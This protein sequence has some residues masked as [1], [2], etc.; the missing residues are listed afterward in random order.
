MSALPGPLSA[1]EREPLLHELA[2]LLY[3]AAEQGP[4]PLHQT[5]LPQTLHQDVLVPS[6][7]LVLGDRG[8]GKSAL[9]GLLVDPPSTAELRAL[10][11]QPAL[12]E[13][14]YVEGFTEFGM[15]HPPVTVLED[16]ALRRSGPAAVRAVWMAHLLR[17][18]AAAGVVARDDQNRWLMDDSGSPFGWMALAPERVVQLQ[19]QLDEAER[20]LQQRGR[21]VVV[22]YDQLDR[23]GAHH[24]EVQRRAIGTLLSLWL[25]LSQRYRALRGKIFLRDDV[26]ERAEVDFPD[27]SKLRRSQS[28]TLRWSESDL[29]RVALRHMVVLCPKLSEKLR[30]NP[31]LDGLLRAV[32]GFGE[33]P[34]AMPE[35]MQREFLRAL[36]GVVVG[37]GLL[38][39]YASRWLLSAILDGRRQ[40]A[41]RAMLSAIGGAAQAALTGGAGAAERLLSL[42]ELREGVRNAGLDRLRELREAHPVVRRVDQLK[43]REVPINARALERWL[44]T[45]VPGE[46]AELAVQGGEE[47]RQ[48]LLRLGV[49][50]PPD[51][52]GRYDLPDLFL[53]ALGATRVAVE[54]REQARAAPREDA[55]A[56]RVR[57][58]EAA[59]QARQLALA[60]REE[61]SAGRP[62]RIAVVNAAFQDAAALLEESIEAASPPPL[63]VLLALAEAHID[64]LWW[65]QVPEARARLTQVLVVLAPWVKKLADAGLAEAVGLL[66]DRL[67]FRD[68]GDAWGTLQE[69][70]KHYQLA[71]QWDAELITPRLCLARNCLWRRRCRPSSPDSQAFLDEAQEAWRAAAERVALNQQPRWLRAWL[72]VTEGEILQTTALFGLGGLEALGAALASYQEALKIDANDREGLVQRGE[73]LL[74]RA[75]QELPEEQRST[76]AEAEVCF[77]RALQVRY[78]DPAAR[79]GLALL[80]IR[81]TAGG[82]PTQA[83]LSVVQEELERVED[84][85]PR[86]AVYPLACLHGLRGDRALC[87]YYLQRSQQLAR[88]LPAAWLKL[89]PGLAGMV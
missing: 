20:A 89:E 38:Q 28:V 33:I 32:P 86:S 62:R 44:A 23:I 79:A 40:G 65:L 41:P 60:T 80:T 4:A 77:Q 55:A 13:Q 16:F 3:R 57:A 72:K 78:Q 34:R 24:A 61:A 73:A 10:F 30:E 36:A 45:A 74:L 81:R 85:S 69:A 49:L 59:G 17:Q 26:F 52:H 84:Q 29:F 67:A 42:D 22:L 87:Q 88:L 71:I 25:S 15:V 11:D 83:G 63:D 14:L 46:P 21:A 76:Q 9:F 75:L 64:W 66:Q 31:V 2:R 37:E 82:V 54:G 68:D 43:G 18:L 7:L 50:S 8:M 47:V 48:L 19:V 39:V 53:Y 51:S 12:P 56:L 70:A 35:A 6:R 5:F 27:I 1:Q 58:L